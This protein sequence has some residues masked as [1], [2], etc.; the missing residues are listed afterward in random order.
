MKI[1]DLCE[2]APL[3]TENATRATTIYIEADGQ[4]DARVINVCARHL[5]VLREHAAKWCAADPSLTITFKV[6]EL[7]P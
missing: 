1:I 7:A 4:C 3:C 6:T 2:A 5:T